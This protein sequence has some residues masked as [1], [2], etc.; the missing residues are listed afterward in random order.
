MC[1]WWGSLFILSIIKSLEDA[2]LLNVNAST[3]L[4]DIVL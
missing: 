4:V 1:V 2:V 3:T